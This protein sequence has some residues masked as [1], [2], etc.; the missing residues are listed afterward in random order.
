LV[1][2]TANLGRDAALTVLAAMNAKYANLVDPLLTQERVNAMIRELAEDVLASEV[3]ESFLTV[4]TPE[5]G[6]PTVI[7]VL[8]LSR[9]RSGMG[10]A[11]PYDGN[12]YGFLGEVEEGQ[13]PPL[14][15][16]LDNLS[17]RQALAVR[18][19][20][21]GAEEELN[22]W[23]GEGPG[24]PRV[25][26][27]VDELVT[28]SEGGLATNVKVP[29]LQY[30][31]TA[32]TPYFMA[33]QSP[34]AACRTLRRLTEG[35]M[36]DQQREHTVRLETWMRAACMRSGPIGANRY[37]SKLHMTWVVHRAVLDRSMAR[38]A[39]RRLALFL[40]N[41]TSGGAAAGGTSHR[42]A[43]R[44]GR[45]NASSHGGGRRGVWRP[46]IRGSQNKGVQPPQA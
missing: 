24:N 23:Y 45:C 32:W 22:V 2:K 40:T 27:Q 7:T 36:T 33:A 9:F 31:P 5:G 35:H 28:E 44:N 6:T 38:W 42:P 25:P 30:I 39:T 37:R 18:E 29:L 21:A 13:L 46:P 43:D 17:L 34:E 1:V 15:K 3:L 19:V 16:L 14:M 41:G 26:I 12:V 10:Q 20:V 8:R 11:S 4:T